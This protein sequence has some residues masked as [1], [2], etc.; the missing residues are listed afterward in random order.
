MRK[1]HFTA[2]SGGFEQ[3]RP[4]FG[5]IGRTPLRIIRANEIRP[6]DVVE[7]RCVVVEGAT[8][9]SS[10]SSVRARCMLLFA[11][12]PLQ[13][14]PALEIIPSLRDSRIEL[15]F[16]EW[17]RMTMVVVGCFFVNVV[18]PFSSSV[19]LFARYFSVG[20]AT[21]MTTMMF[22]SLR[23]IVTTAKRGWKGG[24]SLAQFPFVAL[25]HHRDILPIFQS[26]HHHH[27]PKK[28][29][30]VGGDT[31]DVMMMI[32]LVRFSVGKN[33]VIVIVPYLDIHERSILWAGGFF[34]SEAHPRH[35]VVVVDRQRT[36]KGRGRRTRRLPL[37]TDTGTD[38][39]TAT[40]TT[41]TT[42]PQGKGSRQKQ[43]KGEEQHG[44][45]PAIIHH[46]KND[47]PPL[48][49]LL[50]PPL[51][52]S[53][54]IVLRDNG[55]YYSAPLLRDRGIISHR[56]RIVEDCTLFVVRGCRVTA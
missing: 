36:K 15:S 55:R 51:L 21:M 56:G 3:R 42:A 23:V 26:H 14:P 50:L 32:S 54:R 43:R 38:T 16:A 19:G 35:M 2:F 41:T 52:P 24:V 33:I 34:I 53:P 28:R 27:R 31:L 49:L 7:G 5:G 29:I 18:D 22:P 11:F 10:S 25:R 9:R 30:I 47:V 13:I 48:L 6:I 46:G 12:V 17:R 44:H 1:P 45:H 40:A 4:D 20:I 8:A 37:P 39:A